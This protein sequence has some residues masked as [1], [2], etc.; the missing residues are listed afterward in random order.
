MKKIIFLFLI[1]SSFIFPKDHLS[2]VFINPGKSDELFWTMVSDFMKASANDLGINLE[3]K[4][5]ERNFLN[6]IK[7]ANEIVSRKVKPD[8]VI[9]VNEKLVADKLI[10]LFEK[11]NIKTFLILNELT[12]EQEKKIGKPRT[13]NKNYLGS[14]VPDNR[15]AGYLIAKSLDNSVSNYTSDKNI[16]AIGG[17]RVTPAGKQRIEG[18]N[19]YLKENKNM[20]YLQTVYAE[21]D[22]ETSYSMT[23]GLLKRYPQTNLIWAANDPMAIGAIGASEVF[24]KSVGENIFVSGLNWSSESLEL[25]KKGIMVSSVGGH[26]T[27]GG[28]ALVVLYDYHYGFDFGT[29]ANNF[30][31][32]IDVFDIIDKNN[33]SLYEKLLKKDY[34]ENI[35]FKKFSL[36]ENKSLKKH[37]F[38]LKELLK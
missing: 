12:A 15:K 4:Y 21:W 11:N 38:S 13:N 32:V 5:G 3:I 18:L 16:I 28:F 37:N 2:I 33:I 6:D 35:D 22:L 8:Y 14:I 25:I 19:K 20:N 34:W 9:I 10:D 36:K 23:T 7:I 30:S 17:N 1:I 24:G 27:V 29:K 26:F 31:L